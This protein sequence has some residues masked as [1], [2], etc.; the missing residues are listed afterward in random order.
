MNADHDARMKILD[1]ESFKLKASL[2]MSEL[3][4]QKLE[5]EIEHYAVESNSLQKLCDEMIQGC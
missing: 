3:K 4:V 2:R 1:N 5:N